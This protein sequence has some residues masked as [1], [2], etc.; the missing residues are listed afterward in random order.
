MSWN[1]VAGMLCGAGIRSPDLAEGLAAFAAEQAVC[2]EDRVS[3]WAAKW[4]PVRERV[5]AA[6]HL[7][8]S[9][10]LTSTF[11]PLHV[12]IDLQLE[13]EA[14]EEDEDNKDL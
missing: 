1:S 14:E 2:E 12:D 4:A 7:M 5:Q 8:A 10:S 9:G 3:Q 11:L 6:L 13:D